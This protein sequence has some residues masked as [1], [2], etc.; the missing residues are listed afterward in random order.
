VTPREW[1]AAL[2]EAAAKARAKAGQA[3]VHVVVAGQPIRIRVAPKNLR[4]LLDPLAVTDGSLEEVRT[5]DLWDVAACGV[6]PPRL[7]REA[8]QVGGMGAINWLSS[9]T[10]AGTWQDG[11]LLTWDAVAGT[12]SGWIGD[13]MRLPA[14][15]RAA[16][17][18]AA[19][20]WV[21]RGPRRTLMHAAAIGRGGRGL[22]IG[23]AGGSGKSTTAL[24][25]LL[26]GGDFAGENDVLVDLDGSDGPAAAPVYANAKV[27]AATIRLLPELAGIVGPDEEELRG[28][29]VLD[30]RK[31]RPGQ[32]TG[33]IPIAAIVVPRVAGSALPTVKPIGAAAALRAIAPSSI[34]QLPGERG[35]LAVLA[36]LVR[37]LPSFELELAL[38][39]A[40][41][42]EALEGVL[43][44]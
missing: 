21:L 33:P 30:I 11:V 8:R 15:H 32:P 22:L 44:A 13:S 38:D 26:S 4:A 20:N 16:P 5:I 6:P 37:E 29:S 2:E 24:S 25:W 23:G 41:N 43:P 27:D 35:G 39:P 12:V 34:L 19:L 7:P 3:D 36:A 1:I 17:L 9:P 18:R 10:T 40:A 28:K 31:L 42:V 14:W